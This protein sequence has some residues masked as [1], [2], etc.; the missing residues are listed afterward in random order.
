MYIVSQFIEG[1]D[2]AGRLKP[3]WPPRLQAVAILAR[4][5]EAL[6][7]AHRKGLVHRDI[8]PANILLDLHDE[9]KVADFGLALAEEDF[10]G[11]AVSPA[12]WRT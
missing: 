1:T 7:H 3:G 2:L 8:K 9:A 4:A 5:A 12:R 6:E 10:G 11:G